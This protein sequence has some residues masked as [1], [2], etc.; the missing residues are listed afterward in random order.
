M[1]NMEYKYYITLVSS[2]TTEGTIKKK[3]VSHVSRTISHWGITC[4]NT[5]CKILDK[6]EIP[7]IFFVF[8]TNDFLTGLQN[9]LNK[10][11]QMEKWC[12]GTKTV[13]VVYAKVLKKFCQEQCVCM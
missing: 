1:E 4:S 2:H 11:L 5:S 3:I 6:P 7:L 9:N 13:K 12:V 10:R 8:H